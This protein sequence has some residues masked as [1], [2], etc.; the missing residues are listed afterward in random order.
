MITEMVHDCALLIF[1]SRW[2]QTQ[3]VLGNDITA[4]PKWTINFSKPLQITNFNCKLVNLNICL[5]WRVLNLKQKSENH[6]TI[7]ID[8]HKEELQFYSSI[9]SFLLSM[10]LREIARKYHHHLPRLDIFSDNTLKVKSLT[11]NRMY[12]SFRVL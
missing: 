4:A 10:A 7:K 12:N 9:S 2:I 6:K 3:L 1:E 11:K 5:F 8:T